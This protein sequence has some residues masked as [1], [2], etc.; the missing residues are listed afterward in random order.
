MLDILLYCV[1]AAAVVRCSWLLVELVRV[2]PVH[3]RARTFFELPVFLALTA[4]LVVRALPLPPASPISLVF[5]AVGTLLAFAGVLVSVWAIATTVRRRRL[6][7]RL[8]RGAV[9]QAAE[10]DVR[11]RLQVA[12]VTL[13]AAVVGCRDHPQPKS[14]YA[15]VDANETA[16]RR[17]WRRP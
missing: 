1:T 12:V 14:I 4:L 3:L 10:A 16:A 5:A 11:G 9:Q 8:R 15:A 13:V 6:V 17:R 2:I 7:P